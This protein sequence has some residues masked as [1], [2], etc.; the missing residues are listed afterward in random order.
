MKDDQSPSL[1]SKALKMSDTSL[2][3]NMKGRQVKSRRSKLLDFIV[4]DPCPKS[5]GCARSSINGWDWRRW[6]QKASPGDRSWVRVQFGHPSTLRSVVWASQNSSAKGPSA[7][8]NRVKLRNLLA[9]AEGSELLK[10]TQLTV[11]NA[12]FTSVEILPDFLVLLLTYFYFVRRERNGFVF[13][14]AK[15]MTGVWW[16]WS[17]S[18]QKTL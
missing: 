6:S 8:T 5:N 12:I 7:R 2:C 1:P 9:A 10:I 3:K 4:S 13:K 15:F 16:L 14:G 18:R 17:Q 11:F